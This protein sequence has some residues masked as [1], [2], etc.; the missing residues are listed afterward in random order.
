MR[1]LLHAAALSLV[2]CFNPSLGNEPFLCGTGA[3]A[4]PPGYTC[5]SADQTCVRPGAPAADARPAGPDGA[6]C[7]PAGARCD[8]DDLVTCDGSTQTR[9]TCAAGCDPSGVCQSLS[10]SNLLASACDRGGSE[11]RHVTANLDLNTTT[12]VA[13]GGGVVPQLNAPD[14][15]VF[16]FTNLTVDSGVKVTVTGERIPVFITTGRLELDGILDVS[17]SGENPGPGASPGRMPGHGSSG[18]ANVPVGGGGAGHLTPGGD[19]GGSPSLHSG[20]GA[21]G[22]DD[23]SPIVA[24]AFGGAGGTPCITPTCTARDAG[25][26]GGGAVQIVACQ[27]LVIGPAA[28]IDAG[29]GGGD[30]GQPTGEGLSPG[31]GDGGGSGGSV[32]I[33]APV[34]SL[35]S[36]AQIVANGGGGGSGGGPA[37]AGRPGADGQHSAK[38]APGGQGGTGLGAPGGTG[39]VGAAPAAQPTAGGVLAAFGDGGGGGAA[40]KIRFN[41]RA[42]KPSYLPA[43]GALVSPA[44]ILGA[45]GLHH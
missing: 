45:V 32:L 31:G 37:T 21:F 12:C 14:L 43:T 27:E 19:G 5:R 38:P 9:V 36:G 30:G 25:G 20:G 39:G 34:V 33:E 17:A 10:P 1:A 2:A 41:T 28:L 35:P 16:R 15:C 11:D 42:D 13:S 6:S 24:G 23:L 4:C 29:G 40:G 7:A 44:P 26:A 3:T 22:G 8:G 18:G